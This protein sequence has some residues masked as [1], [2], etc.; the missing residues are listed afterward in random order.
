MAVESHPMPGERCSQSSDISRSVGSD[1]A[2][3]ICCVASSDAT[4][5]L[6][7]MYR[8]RCL[9]SGLVS[10]TR[11]RLASDSGHSEVLPRILGRN[12]RRL[13][14]FP[15]GELCGHSAGS[16]SLNAIGSPEL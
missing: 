1:A 16:R 4:Q 9:R 13:M 2:R 6:R 7:R 14:R 15:F 5:R 8:Q 3:R 12:A 11:R 10:R